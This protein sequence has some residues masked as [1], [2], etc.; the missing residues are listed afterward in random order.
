MLHYTIE[1]LT[2]ACSE[3]ARPSKSTCCKSDRSS[4]SPRFQRW[5]ILFLC[6]RLL[7]KRAS[8]RMDIVG[9]C[10]GNNIDYM[11][12]SRRLPADCVLPKRVET[13][14]RTHT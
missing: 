5:R 8:S 10:Q 9:T 6:S 4:T 11:F 14:A 3:A 1:L 2:M 7:Q 12:E 13:E